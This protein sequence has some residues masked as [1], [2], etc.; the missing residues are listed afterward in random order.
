MIKCID[1]NIYQI[2]KKNKLNLLIFKMEYK[3]LLKNYI[4]IW[5]IKII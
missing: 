3:L 4:I 2:I 1:K 5:K